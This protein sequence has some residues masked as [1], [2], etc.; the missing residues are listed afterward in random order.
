MFCLEVMIFNSVDCR[1]VYESYKKHHLS[2]PVIMI[3]GNL[4][5]LSATSMKSPELLIRVLFVRA[6]A[7]EIPNV[8]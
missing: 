1:F 8:G 6:S 3:L 7:F 4:E 2:S 5:S